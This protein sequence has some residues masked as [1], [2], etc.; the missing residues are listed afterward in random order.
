MSNFYTKNNVEY[1]SDIIEYDNRIEYYE[2]K[3]ESR[4]DIIEYDNRMVDNYEIE[5]LI[6]LL[7]ALKI[8][9]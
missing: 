2:N 7:L 6:S 3:I 9:C 5:D 4:E 8:F 1:R